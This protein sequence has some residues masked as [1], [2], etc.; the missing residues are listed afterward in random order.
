MHASSSTR[1]V[2]E[3]P[4]GS[5]AIVRTSLIYLIFP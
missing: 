4:F 3:T 1:A 2:Q 5:Y